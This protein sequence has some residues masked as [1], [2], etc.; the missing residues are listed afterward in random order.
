MPHSIHTGETFK[1]LTKAEQLGKDLE[2]SI[3]VDCEFSHCALDGLQ[4]YGA[5]FTRCHFEKVSLYW[6]SA[7]QATFIDCKFLRCDL[8]GDFIEARFIRCGFD[9]CET[10]DNNLG[11]KTEWTNAV[12]VECVTSTPLPIIQREDE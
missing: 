7:F 4:I 3:W 5:I 12:T 9:Q 1:K 11:G 6:C 2:N 10:G 8:R